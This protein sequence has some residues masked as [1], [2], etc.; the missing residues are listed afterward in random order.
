MVSTKT[1]FVCEK[2]G[3]FYENENDAKECEMKPSEDPKYKIG[4]YLNI[5]SQYMTTPSIEKYE[6][7]DI[8][9]K[10]QKNTH[11]ILYWVYAK[12]VNKKFIVP[13]KYLVKT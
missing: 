10:I 13:E 8:E 4:E 12:I 6:V 1:V 3:A 9:P 7:V 11:D 5:F 2:C